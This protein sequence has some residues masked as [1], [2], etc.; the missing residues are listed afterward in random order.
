M[1]PRFTDEGTG[2]GEVKWV[3]KDTPWSV[4]WQGREPG[5]QAS[6]SPG[7]ASSREKVAGPCLSSLALAIPFRA[8]VPHMWCPWGINLS[9]VVLMCPTAGPLLDSQS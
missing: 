7:A 4:Q 8:S 1:P 2:H 3:T 9:G 6:V 5:L